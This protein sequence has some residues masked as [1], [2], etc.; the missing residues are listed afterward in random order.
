MNE[1]LQ[2][3]YNTQQSSNPT[4]TKMR[5]LNSGYMWFEQRDT[6]GVF[7]NNVSAFKSLSFKGKRGYSSNIISKSVRESQSQPTLARQPPHRQNQEGRT[8]GGIISIKA[9]DGKTKYALVQG[10][11]TGK[12]SFP[13]GHSNKDEEPLECTKREVAEETGIEELPEPTDCL[14]I[15]YGVY[16]VFSLEDEVQLIPKDNQEIMSTKWVTLEEMDEMSLN[17]DAN[18]YKKQIQSNE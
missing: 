9:T 18:Y 13:K 17:S 7:Y 4:K 8:Y 3:V 6:K 2:K 1:N 10:R 14:K 12:W 16:Y 11:Y 15:G 5:T